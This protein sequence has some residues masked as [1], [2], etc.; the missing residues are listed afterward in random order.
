MA[1]LF[2]KLFAVF[3]NMKILAK[4]WLRTLEDLRQAKVGHMKTCPCYMALKCFLNGPIPTPFCLFSS[5]SLYNSNDTKW[6]K[7]RWCAW[8]SNPGPQDGRRRQNHRAV[9]KKLPEDWQ[10]PPEVELLNPL[11]CEVTAQ[12]L[13]HCI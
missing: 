4:L 13:N 10:Q 9:A 5:V 11:Y 7:R 6:K 1:P 3:S 2:E 8:D 12:W